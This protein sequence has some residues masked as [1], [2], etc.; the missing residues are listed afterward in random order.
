[1]LRRY[2]IPLLTALPLP[3]AAGVLFLSNGT[4]ADLPVAGIIRTPGGEHINLDR[5]AIRLATFAPATGDTVA[6][7][8]VSGEIVLYRDTSLAVLLAGTD[9]TLIVDLD[10]QAAVYDADFD[11]WTCGAPDPASADQ[12]L[13]YVRQDALAL[14]GC[15]G[16]AL[17]AGAI[18]AEDPDDD[19]VTGSADNCPT[20]ANPGQLDTDGD[21]SGD[22]C[23]PD[24]DGDNLTD[25]EETDVYETN[26]R[27]A[28]T[29]GD[30][31]DDGIEVAAGTDPTDE[32]D[33]PGAPGRARVPLPPWLAPA[34]VTACAAFAARRRGPERVAR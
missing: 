13:V 2:L 10:T 9:P 23:D 8:P 15:G 33:F 24:D 22:A 7:D 19:G 12:T 25:V 18:Y 27:V 11:G 5:L 30:G 4:A 32:N 21:G 28:D 31:V 26:P 29:D 14:T 34:L 6:V 20:I 1:V 17:T 3:A 16:E